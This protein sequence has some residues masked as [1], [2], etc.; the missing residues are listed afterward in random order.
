[1]TAIMCSLSVPKPTDV[2]LCRYHAE[3]NTQP[4]LG[5]FK[6]S[7]FVWVVIFVRLPATATWHDRVF[8]FAAIVSLA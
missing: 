2:A 6:L 8:I 4:D 5:F 7:A 3:Q 1:M